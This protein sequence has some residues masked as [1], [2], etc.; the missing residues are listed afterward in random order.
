MHDTALQIGRLALQTY[1]L[2]P[3][4]AI[5]ELGSLDVNGSLRSYAPGEA[6]YIGIDLE[7]GPGVDIITRAGDPIPADDDSFDLVIA[8]SVLEH[9]PAFW[10]T[11]L[12]MCRKARSGGYVY[13]NAPSN[14]AVHRY[15]EDHWR[16]YPDS[17]KALMRWAVSQG[18]SVE[19]IESFTAKR[20]G[21]IWNDFVA[22]FRKGPSSAALPQP[23]LY[24]KL[25]GSRN[26]QVGASAH[27]LNPSPNTED[28]DLLA[29][30]STDYRR[31]DAAR[32]DLE[33][34]LADREHR[35]AHLEDVLRQRDEALQ[36]AIR[37]SAA[38]RGE[39]IALRADADALRSGSDTLRSDA[40]ALRADADGLRKQIFVLQEELAQARSALITDREQI[41]A[42]TDHV[43]RMAIEAEQ[44]ADTQRNA[45][46]AIS[47]AVSRNSQLATEIAGLTRQLSEQEDLALHERRVVEWVRKVYAVTDS[48]RWWW[49]LMPREWQQR[50]IHNRL[51]QRG[52]FNAAEYCS[53][54]PDVVASGMDPLRHYML[55]GLAERRTI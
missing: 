54:Y 46:I 37:E 27:F 50:R 19:L 7:K 23:M 10:V 22:V 17:G 20:D 55:H 26:V 12:E 25:L 34:N 8:S 35:V 2:T 24:E 52:L 43:A 41:R 16:F 51:A 38:T 32:A 13:I 4:P 48:G 9:D 40:D 31:A 49:R 28:M 6:S 1:C 36:Q 30:V 14:G 11:F 42:L 39:A 15:P 29:K 33:R 21:D 18:Q 5:L 47:D 44:V 45:Q 3:N 53:R